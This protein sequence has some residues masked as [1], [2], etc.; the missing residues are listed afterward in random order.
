MSCVD[1]TCSWI[2]GYL[3]NEALIQIWLSESGIPGNRFE[4]GEK[5]AIDYF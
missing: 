2:E 3:A 4:T 1:Q 5:N